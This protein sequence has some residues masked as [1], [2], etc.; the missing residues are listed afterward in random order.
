ML[1]P[2]HGQT[3]SGAATDG[4]AGGIVVPVGT[5]A[6][7]PGTSWSLNAIGS[8]SGDRRIARTITPASPGNGSSRVTASPSATSSKGKVTVG[9]V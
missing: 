8:P 1:S 4:S 2:G 3:P 5:S 6:A 7:G 9:A